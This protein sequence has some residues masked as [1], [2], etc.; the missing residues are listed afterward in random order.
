M[1]E[2]KDSDRAVECERYVLELHGI[3]LGC[4]RPPTIGPAPREFLIEV[5]PP[6]LIFNPRLS[7]VRTENIMIRECGAQQDNARQGRVTDVDF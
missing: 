1:I 3:L 4:A 2:R 5:W 6:Y 7:M